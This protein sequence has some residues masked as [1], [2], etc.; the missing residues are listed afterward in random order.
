MNV[1]INIENTDGKFVHSGD[2]S[3][4]AIAASAHLP[5]K[6]INDNYV[7]NVADVNV[8]N[9][10]LI[11][12]QRNKKPYL[13][14]KKTDAENFVL[15]ETYR[16]NAVRDI[17]NDLLK[18]DYKNNLIEQ[19][20]EKLHSAFQ[21]QKNMPIFDINGVFFDKNIN[22]LF[23][24]KGGSFFVLKKDIIEQYQTLALDDIY[25]LYKNN[26]KLKNY[27]ETVSIDIEHYFNSNSFEIYDEFKIA[28]QQENTL[29][30]KWLKR[31]NVDI[32]SPILYEWLHVAGKHNVELNSI[33]A[34]IIKR[35][36]FNI[37][38]FTDYYFKNDTTYPHTEKFLES[39]A[40]E[41]D[42]ILFSNSVCSALFFTN[43]KIA[44]SD[45]KI[46]SYIDPIK[47]VHR[48]IEI[49]LINN[50]HREKLVNFFMNGT[51]RIVKNYTKD[52]EQKIHK[53]AETMFNFKEP[54]QFVKNQ[55]VLKT[56]GEEYNIHYK[57]I[58]LT[59]HPGSGKTR[60]SKEMA[61]VLD[62]PFVT[63][64]LSYITAGF[65]L[66]GLDFSW[67]G[68]KQGKIFD[69]LYSQPY[70]NPCVLLDEIDKTL[71]SR[72]VSNET[73]GSLYPLLEKDTSS[74]FIDEAIG[75]EMD[76]SGI[77]WM[78]TSN[79]VDSLPE[80]IVSR[81]HV[82][83]IKEITGSDKKKLI[84][85]IYNELLGNNPWGSKFERHLDDGIIEKLS[86][87]SNREISLRLEEACAT[88]ISKILDTQEET[89]TIEH[90]LH[91]D[92]LNTPQKGKNNIGFLS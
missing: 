57:P 31:L 29:F 65:V 28:M 71:S 1:I 5:W 88:H 13:F 2:L 32:E 52:F 39:K 78:A 34:A 69:V 84:V 17:I 82:F 76:A 83:N 22:V 19:Y 70:F 87:F 12:C 24:K 38:V 15:N 58:L 11:F 26:A 41:I 55:K 85:N 54:I 61:D 51:Y 21:E 59:G 40:F 8:Y 68:G 91:I 63:I 36:L 16:I 66:S 92:D 44:I 64:N 72:G 9:Y 7:L 10:S 14:F 27:V 73:L 23:Q 46:K 30:F 25:E 90:V 75:L 50:E 56:F 37:P 33:L 49:S 79:D 43:K 20:L 74:H 42:E 86:N 80:P 3:E 62:V 67:K 48:S 45:E 6:K 18:I 35:K 53:L 89:A 77:L 47:F 81:L 4:K 60:F